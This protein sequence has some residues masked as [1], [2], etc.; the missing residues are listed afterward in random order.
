MGNNL[1]W[2]LHKMFM[3]RDFEFCKKL[4]AQQMEQNF[5]QEYLFFVKVC[6]KAVLLPHPHDDKFYLD[7][8]YIF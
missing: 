7:C 4:V 8:F 5:N 6:P 1:N 3:I 2:L